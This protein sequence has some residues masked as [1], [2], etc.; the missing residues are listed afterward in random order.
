MMGGEPLR[1]M[2]GQSMT[3]QLQIQQ[4]GSCRLMVLHF[5]WEAR[6]HKSD[7]NVNKTSPPKGK[8]LQIT[9]NSE[10]LYRPVIERTAP[11]S[12]LRFLE[13]YQLVT[14]S[15]FELMHRVKCL[16]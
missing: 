5:I 14:S 6:A 15:Y 1:Q 13:N 16:L 7:T 4:L 10:S 9:F 3:L 8:Y 11:F 2:Q 12:C